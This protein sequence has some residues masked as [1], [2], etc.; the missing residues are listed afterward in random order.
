VIAV[1]IGYAFFIWPRRTRRPWLLATVAMHLGIAL[2]M[3]L[4]VF[5]AIMIAFTV[6]IFG[7]SA[8]P[9]RAERVAPTEPGPSLPA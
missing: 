4:S 9:A 8:E 1:E 7:F 3:G 6:A 2:F 5:A